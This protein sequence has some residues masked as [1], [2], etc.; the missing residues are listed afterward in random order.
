MMRLTSLLSFSVSTLSLVLSASCASS[1]PSGAITVGNGGKYATLS[2]A[3]KDTS[4]NVYFV[5]AGTYKDQAA[6]TRS[7]VK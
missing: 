1:P 3:L 2:A 5:Y 4:S 6:I 7:G